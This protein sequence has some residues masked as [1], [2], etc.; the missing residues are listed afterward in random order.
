MEIYYPFNQVKGLI[1]SVFPDYSGRKDVIVEVVPCLTQFN[2]NTTWSGGSCSNYAVVSREN[3]QIA[4]VK[5]DLGNMFLQQPTGQFILTNGFLLFK[6]QIFQG[7][8]LPIRVFVT[9]D[10][11][12]LLPPS[13]SST[14]E[15]TN[16]QALVLFTYRHFKAGYAGESRLQQCNS[17][18]YPSYE[19]PRRFNQSDWDQTV[20]ELQTLGYLRGKTRISISTEG[21]NALSQFEEKEGKVDYHAKELFTNRS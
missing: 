10:D 2:L 5:K 18:Y 3:F 11:F 6:K 7:K 4:Q 8:H 17:L 14:T 21:K 20:S 16:S 15:L 12:K 19:N 13:E 9:E 1:L